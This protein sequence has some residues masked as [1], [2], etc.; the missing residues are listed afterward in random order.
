MRRTRG[1]IALVTNAWLVCGASLTAVTALTLLLWNPQP[2]AERPREL[3][4]YCAA[5]LIQPVEA[6]RQEYEQAHGVKIQVEPDGS[7]KL[8]SKLRVVADRG[9]LFLAA[10]SSY[11]DLAHK[12][13]LIAETI[14]VASIHPVI[15]T[16]PQNPKQITNARDLLRDNV[17]VALANP[18]LAAVGQAT[19]KALQPTGEWVE[20]EKQSKRFQAK[21][22]L[23]GTVNEVAQAVKLGTVDAGIVWD[24][25]ARQFDLPIVEVPALTAVREQI[26]L[27]VLQRTPV[28][29]QA[30]HF[31]RYLTARD[32]G[33][34]QFRRHHFTPAADSDRWADVP[35]VTLMIGA[36]LR[37]GVE[38]VLKQFEK[39]EGVQITPIYNG[40]G[41]LVAQMK[42]GIIPDAYFACDQSFLDQVAEEYLP[43]TTLTEND[44]VILVAKGNPCSIHRLDDLLKPGLR[45]GLAHPDKSALGWLALRLLERQG[46]AEKFRASGNWKV[47]SATGDYLVNQLLTDALDAVIVYRS[48]A[49]NNPDILGQRLDLIE[50]DA[51]RKS[52][53]Q[54]FAIA[55]R[56]VY[57]QLMRRLLEAVTADES[58]HRFE[59]LG[60]RWELPPE[61]R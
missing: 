23:V 46:L 17:K 47:D 38:P 31:A 37:P 26:T 52:A 53:V 44:M 51:P 60:F 57:P 36:M 18:E 59:S 20:L 49:Q 8:L 54:P 12:E 24:A 32:K 3:V 61:S 27:G 42:S 29:K 39:R 34:E 35:E 1:R 28:P 16:H 10:D 14:P 55:K 48:N 25:T 19:R 7:G 30:L 58:R 21:V 45:V 22:S 4:L 9:D 41:I 13:G 2:K 11:I 40:C 56:S 33:M 5:G 50:I 15:V 6:I 43:H